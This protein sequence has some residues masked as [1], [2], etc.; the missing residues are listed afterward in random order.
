MRA[1]SISRFKID[2]FLQGKMKLT[3]NASSHLGVAWRLIG[4]SWGFYL[5]FIGFLLVFYC[6]FIS[7]RG[8]IVELCAK[9]A[10]AL[11]H[12]DSRQTDS[13]YPG[14]YESFIPLLNFYAVRKKNIVT[15]VLSFSSINLVSVSD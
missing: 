3:F 13:R 5:F 6:S 4:F 10:A 12:P 8:F 14:A 7:C 2:G 15:V 1:F 9:R 11:R